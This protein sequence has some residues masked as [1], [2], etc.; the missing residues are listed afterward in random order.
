MTV[1]VLVGPA[2][3]GKTHQSIQQVL[4]V[5][6]EHPLGPVW[7]IV[8]DRLQAYA[9]RGRIATK[10]G[11]LGVYT[12]TFGDFYAKLLLDFDE[13]IPLASEP[14]VHRF[15]QDSIRMV[16]G[17]EHFSPIADMPGFHKILAGMIDELKL[18]RVWP[19]EF[20]EWT[21]VHGK[22]LGEIAQVYRLYQTALAET[23][24][25]DSAGMGWLATE[26]LEGNGGQFEDVP[27]I[28]VDGF[29]S[30][31]GSQRAALRALRERT[32]DLIITL[33]GQEGMERTAHRR[34]ANALAR[35]QD[36]FKAEIVYL[37]PMDY[38]PPPLSHL[39]RSLFIADAL[40]VSQDGRITMLELRSPR[41]E[42]RE[43]LR[44][45][46]SL[47]VR[48]GIQAHE[49]AIVAPAPERYRAFLREAGTEY[50][51]PLRFTH[52]ESLASAPAITALL[53]LLAIPLSDFP[54]RLTLDAVRAPF[55]DLS[56]IEVMSADADGLDQVSRHGLVIQ[57][58]DQWEEAFIRLEHSDRPTAPDDSRTTALPTREETVRLHEG[59]HNLVQRIT[60]PETA[61]TGTYVRWLEDLL[62][63]FHFLHGGKSPGEE[64]AFLGLR[65][66][67]RALVLGETV[68]GEK[69][70][71]PI[72]FFRALRSFLEG[73][74]YRERVQWTESVVLILRVLEARGLRF[75][76]VAVLGLSEGLFPEVE[77]EDPFLREEMRQELGLEK[78][79]E[80][81]QGGLFYQ[82][83]T[84][85]D[86]YLLLT[87]P[88]L[89]DD[90]EHWEPS[91]FWSAVRS[92]STELPKP[93]RMGDPRALADA[94][95]SGEAL[96]WAVQRRGLPSNYAPNLVEHWEYLRRVS[97]LIE[98]RLAKSAA[99]PYEGSLDA[100]VD[101]LRQRYGPEYVWSASRLEAYSSCPYLFF[102]G[103]ALEMEAIEPPAFGLDA[104]QLGL[105]LHEILEMA[106]REAADPADPEE[107]IAALKKV[108]TAIFEQAPDRHGFRPTAL[109]DVEQGQYVEALEGSVMGLAQE[110]DGWTPIAYERRFGISGEPVLEMVDKGG[111]IRIRGVIDRLDRGAKGQIRVVDYKTGSSHLSSK[112]L[113]SGLRLQLPIYAL[114]ARDALGLGEPVDGFYWMILRGKP[115]S[116]R[117]ARF[118][119][120]KEGVSY[121]GTPGAIALVHEHTQ[122]IVAGVRDGVFPPLPPQGGCPQYCPAAAW[123]WRY[124][125]RRW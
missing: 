53:D 7:V 104:A 50:G 124:S 66:V 9:Y 15:L 60:M 63:E 43:A 88:M 95:S 125:P 89:A 87:R 21:E 114:A 49:C 38:T 59:F 102:V 17:M 30:F 98:S 111:S 96:F 36:E 110:G 20:A 115:G 72:A 12:G 65:G 26:S 40:P 74:N 107:V 57:G 44:W 105:I 108:S 48:K 64:A 91:P 86:E 112:D 22:H 2:A 34:F 81:E 18:A 73:T 93:I 1:R 67:L 77:R 58:L 33:P 42:A 4:Q 71:T 94:A 25:A 101:H 118:T 122:R 83:V 54:R 5:L 11:A 10:G 6:K 92:I 116:L 76:A 119:H 16:E 29:D 19:D 69:Q 79:L 13:P 78:R 39:E 62:E 100:L 46:K 99:G 84:R 103:S 52:G 37:T 117:L 68:A 75:K 106:Y 97:P 55:F 85:A 90:G 51:M 113:L 8:P 47:I 41:E 35:L 31:N 24:W 82:V 109:W 45:I 32:P 23:G 56:S 14:M 61:T 121:R 123:C 70:T 120:E 3:S 27:L 28:V 80:R